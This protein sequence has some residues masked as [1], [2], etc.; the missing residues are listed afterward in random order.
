[1]YT[2]YIYIFFVHPHC[3]HVAGACE[4]VLSH[5][6]GCLTLEDFDTFYGIAQQ[7][8]DAMVDEYQ[9]PM[10]LDQATISNTNHYGHPPHV[11]PCLVPAS[12]IYIY[13]IFVSAMSSALLAAGRT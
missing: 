8:V 2:L 12:L 5:F 13:I 1:M 4:A 3:A 10:L 7:V 6:V 9:V 11:A